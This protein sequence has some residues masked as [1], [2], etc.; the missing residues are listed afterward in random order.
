MD[1]LPAELAL[2]DATAT[3]AMMSGARAPGPHAGAGCDSERLTERWADWAGADEVSSLLLAGTWDGDSS[4]EAFEL[5][6][7][8]CAM[9]DEALRGEVGK[10]VRLRA[11]QHE[12][13]S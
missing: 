13:K 7:D 3:V 2:A 9:L 12:R 1:P 6:V 4:T 5:C 8:G 11:K 10:A